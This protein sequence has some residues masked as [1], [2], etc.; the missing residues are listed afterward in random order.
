MDVPEK[1]SLHECLRSDIYKNLC[2]LR[3]IINRDPPRTER[4]REKFLARVQYLV[5][6]YDLFS[7]EWK[8]ANP[9][10]TERLLRKLASSDDSNLLSRP[11]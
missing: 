2:T 8:R 7:E 3:M 6:H 4:M 9:F 1:E 10:D 11:Y 5:S